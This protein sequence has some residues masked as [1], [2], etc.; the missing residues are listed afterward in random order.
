MQEFEKRL[1]NAFD[2]EDLQ[3][4]Y[5]EIHQAFIDGNLTF[6]DYDTLAFQYRYIAMK[7]GWR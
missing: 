7:R 1:R 5:L 3:K 4:V 2:F 6:A